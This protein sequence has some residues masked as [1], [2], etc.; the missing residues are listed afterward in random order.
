MPSD[1]FTLRIVVPY[2]DPEGIRTIDDP[3]WT[4]KGVIFPRSEWEKAKAKRDELAKA[5]IYILA[6]ANLA[7]GNESPSPESGDDDLPSIYV[8]QTDEVRQPLPEQEILG[9]G[10]CLCFRRTQPRPHN[11]AGKCSHKTRKGGKTL[12]SKKR[13]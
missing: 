5:G 12:P 7:E 10:S 11:L 9:Q 8:G 6:G 13:Q 4:G 2:G 3:N 1:P